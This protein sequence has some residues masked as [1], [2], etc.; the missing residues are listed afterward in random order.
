M[1][2]WVADEYTM[3]QFSHYQ[4]EKG[5]DRHSIATDPRFVDLKNLDFRLSPGSPVLNTSGIG[6]VLFH[7]EYEGESKWEQR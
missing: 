3:A 4:A 1:I 7:S 2:K 5:L 6:A